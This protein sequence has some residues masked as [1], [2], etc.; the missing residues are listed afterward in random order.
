MIGRAVAGVPKRPNGARNGAEYGQNIASSSKQR[1]EIGKGAFRPATWQRN[2]ASIDDYVARG[3]EEQR[4]SNPNLLISP[5]LCN[6]VYMRQIW[7][8]CR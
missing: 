4:K 2:G 6:D 3:E 1:L 8:A 5:M 7:E